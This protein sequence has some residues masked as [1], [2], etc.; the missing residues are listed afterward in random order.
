MIFMDSY[1]RYI[2]SRSAEILL[3][4]AAPR[5]LPTFPEELAAKA[6]RHLE[7]LGV[8]V[9]TNTRVTSVDADGIVAN[10]QRVEA[11]TVLWGA[12]VMASAAAEW[13][14]AKVDKSGKVMVNADMSVPGHAEI[15]TIGDT[16]HVVAGARNLLG[17]KSS[18][19][20]VMPGVA[21]PAIQEGKYVARLIRR[22][23]EG[24]AEPAP[25]WYWDKGD[26]AIVGRT[27]ALADLRFVRFAGFWAWM[28]WAAVHI[29]FLIGFANRFFVILRWGIAFLTK[30]REVRVFPG[31]E[32]G[33]DQDN[34]K[35]EN[36]A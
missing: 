5:I 11:A 17:M 30:Q 31:Q 19:A 29:Y 22:R 32:R 8:K 15:F 26:L 9:F 20:M 34:I 33:K 24:K 6:Q 13:L 7:G 14:G 23:V 12:G 10:G 16:A 27:Y 35:G 36:A 2:D 21:Q 28:V 3:Y 4:E 18:D 25:F 1:F